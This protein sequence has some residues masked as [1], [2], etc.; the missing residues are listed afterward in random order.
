MAEKIV[1]V[2]MTGRLAL[3]GGPV[4]NLGER[5]GL[6]EHLATEMIE[7]GLARRDEGFG[8]DPKD[9]KDPKDAKD[10][11][12]QKER[13]PTAKAEAFASAPKDRMVGGAKA[14]EVKPADG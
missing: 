2:V 14:A 12:D 7:G 4:Y 8:K 6:P 5:V 3:A 1:P 9:P 11:K 10:Q 13:P